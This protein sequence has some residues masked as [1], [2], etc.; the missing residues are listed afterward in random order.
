V[1]API[2]NRYHSSGAALAPQSVSGTVPL[3]AKSVLSDVSPVIVA[4]AMICAP[5]I[6]GPGGWSEPAAWTGDAR[7]TAA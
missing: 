6:T 1:P 4:P 5:V 7:C 2:S 3:S